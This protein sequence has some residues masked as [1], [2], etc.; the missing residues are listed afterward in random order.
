MLDADP[1]LTF[2]ELNVAD[3]WT[4][5]LISVLDSPITSELFD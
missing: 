5:E 2:V 4:E 3:V 1:S